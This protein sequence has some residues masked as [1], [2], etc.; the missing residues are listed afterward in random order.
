MAMVSMLEGLPSNG[1][2]TTADVFAVTLWSALSYQPALD[3]VKREDLRAEVLQAATN[4]ASSS[5]EKARERV[6]V[7]DPTDLKIDIDPANIATSNFKESTQATVEALRRNAA[8]D[9][10]EL[11]FLWW[12]QL[13]RSRLLGKALIAI[14]EPTRIVAAGVE[15]GKMLRRFPC[16]VHREL[17]LRTLENDAQLDLKELIEVIGED[18]TALV[19]NFNES[20]G[21][22]HPTV[23]PLLHALATGDA[24]GPG[25]KEKRLV[26]EWGERALLE[27]GFVKL[28][29]TGKGKL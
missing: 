20:W 6:N 19:V 26:S 11:D 7:P 17:V 14:A 10:E 22:N 1:G 9:R 5:A 15:G 25:A 21:A 18:R 13:T 4:W 24:D 12:V 16:E 23:F 29:S 28:L 3:A 2:W 27:A 8:L